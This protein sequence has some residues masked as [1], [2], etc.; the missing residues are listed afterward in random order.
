M[1]YAVDR[2]RMAAGAHSAATAWSESHQ[3]TNSTAVRVH[4]RFATVFAFRALV[5]VVVSVGVL[6]FVGFLASTPR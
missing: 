3:E 5:S 1:I 2:H 6:L 4:V